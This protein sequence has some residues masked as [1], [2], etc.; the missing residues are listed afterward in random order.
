LEIELPKFRDCR[1]SVQYADEC[2]PP[3]KFFDVGAIVFWAKIIEWS[4]PGFSVEGNFDRL[5]TLQD[6]M[7]QNG[8]VSDLQHRFIIVAENVK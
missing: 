4:F 6:E 1:F 2:F 3:L 5:C 8:F 7:T